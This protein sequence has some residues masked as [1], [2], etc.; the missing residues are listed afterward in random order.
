VSTEN[1]DPTSGWFSDAGI[2]AS[3]NFDARPGGIDISLIVIHAISLP[4]G[5]F[6]GHCIREFF[7]NRLDSKAHPY[8]SGIAGM[9]VSAHLFID[10]D[11]NLEQFV[12]THSRAWHCGQSS[13]AG[14]PACNDFSIGIELEGCDEKAFTEAQYARLVPVLGEL[15]RFHPAIERG[16]IVG[17]CDIAPGRKTDPGPHFDW[18][19]VRTA[20]S[21]HPAGCRGEN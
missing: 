5:V 12:S 7:L 15:L 21:G 3:P 11:G 20:L 18:A 9:K 1:F 8:F 10:R 16:A 14:K 6:G 19:R 17:H 13:Y 4:P 2:F